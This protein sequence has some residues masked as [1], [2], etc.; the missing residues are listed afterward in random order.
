M[1]RLPPLFAA[2]GLLAGAASALTITHSTLPPSGSDVALA[3]D[4]ATY[5]GGHPMEHGTGMSIDVGQTFRLAQALTLDRVTFKVRAVTEIAGELMTIWIGT[6][7][8][9]D[10]SS[11]NQL[12]RVE[13]GALPADLPVDQVRYLTF[14]LDYGVTLEPNQQYGAVIGFTG[15]GHVKDA[16]AE[17]LHL[18]G[19]DY[20]DGTAVTA[21]GAFTATL[22]EDLACFL[23]GGSEPPPVPPTPDPD[24]FLWLRQSRFQVEA[25][26]RT[27]L[28]TEGFAQ[29]VPLTEETGA[30]WFFAAGN[31]EL[32]LK[33]LDACDPFDRYWVFIAGLTDVEVQI[34]VRDLEGGATRTYFN[35]MGQPF[36]PI[37]DASAFATCP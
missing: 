7:S 29:P 32:F 11:L 30:F 34:V 6:Y 13:Y 26:W 18:G 31:L 33:V 37:L 28:G 3:L 27:P 25:Y 8:G 23:Q 17:V 22:E 21:F 24:E 9:G 20:G 1:R 10:D 35:P 19:D 36:Q 2:L 16:R 4:V 14:D 5:Q 12:L 15:G